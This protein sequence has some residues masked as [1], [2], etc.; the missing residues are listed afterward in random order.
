MLCRVL[1]KLFWKTDRRFL[2]FQITRQITCNNDFKDQNGGRVVV[3]RSSLF[4]GFSGLSGFSEPDHATHSVEFRIHRLSDSRT[5]EVQQRTARE[6]LP[7]CVVHRA[8][9]SI[10]R[11]HREALGRTTPLTGEIRSPSTL[12]I[13]LWAL[14]M[15]FW[16]VLLLPG[17]PPLPPLLRTAASAALSSPRL[18]LLAVI[19]VCCLEHVVGSDQV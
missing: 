17:P 4:G 14:W 3:M 12:P 2:L 5:P 13:R 7:P 15:F 1:L 6:L 11:R 18:F 8:A 19:S 10:W 16:A 9:A